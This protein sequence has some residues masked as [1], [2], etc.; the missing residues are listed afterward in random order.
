MLLGLLGSVGVLEVGL[1]AAGD[2]SISHG[3]GGSG[4]TAARLGLLR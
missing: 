2:L 4:G 1:V 3:D